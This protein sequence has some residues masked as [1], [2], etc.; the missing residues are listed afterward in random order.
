MFF[1]IFFLI[2]WYILFAQTQL[3]KVQK[4]FLWAFF[5]LQSRI[6]IMSDIFTWNGFDESVLYHLQTGIGWAGIGS[7]KKIV[8]TWIFLFI[9]LMIFIWIWVKNKKYFIKKYQKISVLFVIWAIVFH[10]LSLNIFELFFPKNNLPKNISQEIKDYYQTAQISGEWNGKNLVYLYLESF[11]DLYL[12]EKIF[13]WLAPNLQEIAKK[14]LK[15]NGMK[16]TFGTQWTI[17]WMVASQCGLPLTASAEKTWN[18]YK[19]TLCLWDILSQKNYKTYYMWGADLWFAGK[20]NFLSE[21]G[22]SEI[23]GKNEFLQSWIPSSKMYDW[24][25]YDDVLFEELE[26]KYNE[27]SQK[28]EKFLL[29]SLTLDTHWEFWVVSP[30]CQNLAYKWEKNILKSYHCTDYLLWEF[31]KNIEKNKAFQNT[32]FVITSDHY[33][34]NHNESSN[35]LQKYEDQRQHLFLIY[36]PGKSSQTLT[37]ASTP[38]DKFPTVLS[39]LGFEISRAGLWINLFWQQK[40]LQEIF[41]NS[42]EILK[43]WRVEYQNY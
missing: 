9:I 7:D 2:I 15:I 29:T 38:F 20:W 32:I 42:Q 14:S 3:T 36:E 16:Q 13:P 12:D 22:Y 34:M 33:A 24:W 5:A 31:F 11:E 27:L 23:I 25:L 17:A 28:N 30:K 37:K 43:S 40:T 21:H 6:Y 4:I 35:I 39:A 1:V 8:L 19:N 41:W 18:I 26:K 10:P